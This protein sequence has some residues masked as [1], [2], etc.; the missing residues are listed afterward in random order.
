MCSLAPLCSYI[1]YLHQP[2]WGAK[3]RTFRWQNSVHQNGSALSRIGA[4]PTPLGAQPA[5]GGL[6]QMSDSASVTADLGSREVEWNGKDHSVVDRKS[7]ERKHGLLDPMEELGQLVEEGQG[8]RR[9]CRKKEDCCQCACLY[10]LLSSSAS[11]PIPWK[12]Y[13]FRSMCDL[14]KAYVDAYCYLLL[15]PSSTIKKTLT[16]SRVYALGYI[17]FTWITVTLS[18]LRKRSKPYYVLA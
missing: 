18:F 10:S 15:L 1:T 6:L 12:L 17:F 3:G 9:S 14:F 13:N 4:G 11:S 2:K 8:R 16:F 5:T 7:V